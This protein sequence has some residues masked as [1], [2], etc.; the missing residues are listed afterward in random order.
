LIANAAS[1]AVRELRRNIGRSLLTGLGIVIGIA[2]VITLVTVGNGAAKRVT[3]DVEKLGT[4]LLI[5]T[6]GSERRGP[7]SSTADPL[8]SADARAI[9]GE[10]GASARTAPSVNRAVLAVAGSRNHN[11]MVTGSTVEFADIRAFR[12]GR[13]RMFDAIEAD[14]GKRVCVLGATTAR[15]LFGKTAPLDVEIR[16]GR[17]AC[18]VIGVFAAKGGSAI[19]GD[20]DEIVVMPLLAVQRRIAGSDD[21]DAVYVSTPTPATVTRTK[22]RIEALMRDRRGLGPG[23][24]SDFSVQDMREIMATLNTITSLLVALLAAVAGVS[25]LVGGIGIMNIMLVSVTERTREIGIRL[26]IGALGGEVLMQFL[27]ESVVL[28]ALGGVIGLGVGVAGS[29]ALCRA[30]ELPFAI[31]IPT[32]LLT[33]GF[34]GLVGVVFG[35]VPARRAARLDP[36]EALRRD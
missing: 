17:L 4:N 33:V 1:M 26:A 24:P 9:A 13:G 16:V 18:T 34:S 25:L 5:V 14:A 20:Q 27:V 12:I 28:S 36:I 10:L 23:V 8:T 22:Q 3:A 32:T 15:E 6:A 35:Y 31:S 7:I 19:G 29:F 30:L 2:A 21:V 11:T